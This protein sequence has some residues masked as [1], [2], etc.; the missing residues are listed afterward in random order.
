MLLRIPI[1]RLFYPWGRNF[2][3]HQSAALIWRWLMPLCAVA[4]LVILAGCGGGSDSEQGAAAPVEEPVRAQMQGGAYAIEIEGDDAMRFNITR[5]L[6]PADVD[7]RLTLTITGVMSRE[8]M[9]HNWVLLSR[10]TPVEIFAEDAAAARETD[11]IPVGWDES[12]LAHTELL[13]GGEQ[14]TIIFRTPEQPGEFVF[15][16]TFPG[17]FYAGMHGVMVVE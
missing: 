5:F 14:T 6:V 13:G 4:G 11:Y 15:L 9:G 1:R 8:M 10:D 7:L 3:T 17:H 12:I 16:C 2:P